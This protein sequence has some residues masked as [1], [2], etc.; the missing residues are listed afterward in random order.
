MTELICT[1]QNP[2]HKS[3]FNDEHHWVHP[4]ANSIRE[5]SNCEKF[6]CPNCKLTFTV[7]YPE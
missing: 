6:E 4:D 1:K 7:E 5:W 2:Y 3:E